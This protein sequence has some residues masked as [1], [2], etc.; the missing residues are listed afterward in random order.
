VNVNSYTTE[1]ANYIA[2]APKFSYIFPILKSLHWL[3]IIINEQI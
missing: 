1:T 3:R 2:K